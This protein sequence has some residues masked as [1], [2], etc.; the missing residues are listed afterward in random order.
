MAHDDCEVIN[1]KER[2][3]TSVDGFG[4]WLNNGSFLTSMGKHFRKIFFIY[5]PLPVYIIKIKLVDARTKIVATIVHYNI[6]VYIDLLPCRIEKP[7]LIL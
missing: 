7:V 1:Y 4:T 5:P 2:K 3:K 6:I